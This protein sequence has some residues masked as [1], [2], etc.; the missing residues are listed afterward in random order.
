[1]IKQGCM[2]RGESSDGYRMAPSPVELST[3]WRISTIILT[4]ES[5]Y[6][7]TSWASG[8]WRKSLILDG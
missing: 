2:N 8:T 1:M 7:N 6:M 5:G 3:R 4:P